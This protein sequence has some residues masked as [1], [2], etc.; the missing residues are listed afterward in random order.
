MLTKLHL[1]NVD[2]DAVQQCDP[3]GGV[4]WIGVRFF[5]KKLKKKNFCVWTFTGH[6]KVPKSDYQSQF[7]TSKIIQ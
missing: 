4:L 7:S 1:N 2:V 6:Q 3:R 5:Q